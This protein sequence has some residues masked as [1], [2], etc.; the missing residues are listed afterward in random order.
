MGSPAAR[1]L[2]YK[3][4]LAGSAATEL[5]S[6]E[7]AYLAKN[8]A[9]EVGAIEIVQPKYR[10]TAPV[11]FAQSSAPAASLTLAGMGHAATPPSP[12]SSGSQTLTYAKGYLGARWTASDENQD[13]LAYSVEIR[14]VSEREWKPL[15]DHVREK[16]LSFDS[17]AFP[18]G[19]YVLRV[20][21]T[22]A[23]GNPPGQALTS[24][25]T[26]EPFVIDN[27]PPQISNLAVTRV[28]N[29]VDVRWK[30]RDARSIVQKAEYSLNGGE[31]LLVLPVTKLFDS[32]E[33]EYR[34]HAETGAQELVVAIRVTDEFGNQATEKVVVR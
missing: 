19:E 16:H 30:T 20:T 29:G 33:E 14:G 31:W 9:P 3:V 24:A 21:A 1:F 12:E 13:T 17:T 5:A 25:L 11:A 4:D 7:L 2:Q 10:F 18:D 22:D 23:P 32:P 8:I 15:K 6:V 26:S 34:L 28:G 27:T